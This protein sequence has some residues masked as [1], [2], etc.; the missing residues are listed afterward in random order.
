MARRN[1]SHATGVHVDARG[2][3]MPRTVSI[4]VQPTHGFIIVVHHVAKKV[5][6]LF[7]L[8]KSH[9]AADEVPVVAFWLSALIDQT[10]NDWQCPAQHTVFA[11]KRKS[12]TYAGILWR[13]SLPC[14]GRIVV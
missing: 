2:L 12:H 1:T 7:G 10:L 5:H 8:K 4:P 6:D 9:P 14:S 3:Q 13:I 11:R